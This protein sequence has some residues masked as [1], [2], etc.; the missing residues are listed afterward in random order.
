MKSLTSYT[1]GFLLSVILT[2]MTYIVVTQHL[3]P[4]FA[5]VIIMVFAAIQMVIQMVFFLH[6]TEGKKPRW[7]L[8]AFF[9]MFVML[10]ILVVASLWIMYS[11]KYNMVMTPKQM[12]Q[13]ML[14]Q[15][16]EG[17]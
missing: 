3:L 8:V 9:F 12:N 10:L 16:K 11:L 6:V 5:N 17:F 15:N 14:E 7:N 2:L 13:Y 1:I 4:N